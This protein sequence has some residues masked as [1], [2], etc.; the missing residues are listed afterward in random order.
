MKVQ[1]LLD[2]I[3]ECTIPKEEST[4]EKPK[5]QWVIHID[6]VSNS[7]G[8]GVGVILMSLKGVVTKYI[9]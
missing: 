3:A 4:M 1:V 5:V 9:L 8:N 6:R 2:F 7:K